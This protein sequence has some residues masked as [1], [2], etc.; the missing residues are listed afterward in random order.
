MIQITC[1]PFEKINHL[2]FIEN[3]IRQ[4]KVQLVPFCAKDTFM[5]VLSSTF[6]LNIED[7]T[8]K[9]ESYGPCTCTI[10]PLYHTCTFVPW[11]ILVLPP[12]R[13]SPVRGSLS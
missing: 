9:R 10:V 4:V 8:W 13:L 12:I 5:A 7:E 2:L 1:F 11:A 3:H 6:Y